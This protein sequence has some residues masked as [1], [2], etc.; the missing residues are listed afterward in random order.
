MNLN[1]AKVTIGLPVYNGEKYVKDAVQ[2]VLSQTHTD[3]RLIISDNS[4]TDNT[5]KICQELAANDSRIQ[6]IKQPENIGA[7]DNFRYVKDKAESEYFLWLAFDDRL[8]PDF[9]AKTVFTLDSDPGCGLV[10]C[11]YIVRNLETNEESLV[12]VSASNSSNA[13]VRCV[14]RL[15]DM[16]PSIIYG[17]HRTSCMK[18]AELENFDFADVHYVMQIAINNR[19]KT[20]CEPGYIAGVK[21]IRTPY[22]L[23]GKKISRTGFLKKEI[24]LFYSNFSFFYASF[25]SLLAIMIMIKNKLV[26]KE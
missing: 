16:C 20:L 8:K 23:T 2:S 6:Y 25:L 21:G 9:L 19:I 15:M 14:I 22:S 26:L 4:S 24:A 10:F 5:G 7:L 11:D 17:L 1:H 12:H 18:K 13:F 3:F